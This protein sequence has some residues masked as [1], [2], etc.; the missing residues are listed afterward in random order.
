MMPSRFRR[1][2]RQLNDFGRGRIVG[3]SETEW[4]YR[5]KGRH[6]Q[7]QLYKSAGSIG[8]WCYLIRQQVIHT[9]LTDQRYVDTILLPNA[10]SLMARHPGA[11]FQQDNAKPHTARISLDCL[12][13]VN[14]LP[15]PAGSPDLSPIEHVWDLVTRQIRTPQNIAD[16]E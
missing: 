4:S 5:A 7:T 12:R 8:C 11:S 10:L 1:L 13:V 3:M 14:T 2:Y 15:L 6:L 9:S 16:L